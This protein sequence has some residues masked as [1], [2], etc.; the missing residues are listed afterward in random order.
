MSFAN[1]GPL[2]LLIILAII[3]LLFGGKKLP[4]LANAL[5]KSMAEFKKGRREGEESAEK[6]VKEIV[7]A[8]KQDLAQEI[9]AAKVESEKVEGA[10]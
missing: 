1:I 10:K 8:A 6:A 4:G 5:A 2:Q 9:P 3:L 7:D